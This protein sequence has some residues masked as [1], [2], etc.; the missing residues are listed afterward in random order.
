MT[1]VG[2]RRLLLSGSDNPKDVCVTERA[3]P[4]FMILNRLLGACGLFMILL[5]TAANAAGTVQEQRAALAEALLKQD[6][7]EIKNAAAVINESIGKKQ[8]VPETPDQYTRIPFDAS[9]LSKA[10][11]IG[12]MP[13][14]VAYIA[15]HRWWR[16]GIDPTK[17]SSPLREQPRP[18]LDYSRSHV[19]RRR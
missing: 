7:Y 3:Y 6:P 2:S 10:E 5:C 18:S 8:G 13:A 4:F 15:Q 11:A 19:F 12:S 16:I 1:L 17:L 9:M 14:M